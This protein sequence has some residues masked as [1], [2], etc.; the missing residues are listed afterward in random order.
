MGKPLPPLPLGADVQ[1]PRWSPQTPDKNDYIYKKGDVSF[2]Y[3]GSQGVPDYLAHYGQ[4]LATS[5][6]PDDTSDLLRC[7]S[8]PGRAADDGS[9]SE[10]P[11]RARRAQESNRTRRR[12]QANQT[13][14]YRKNDGSG[15]TRN[16][17]RSTDIRYQKE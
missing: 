7:S 14:T 2:N 3:Y 11:C 5:T 17:Y 12:L 16:T 6:P 15:W 4:R 10:A 8:R 1:F 9:S 13:P